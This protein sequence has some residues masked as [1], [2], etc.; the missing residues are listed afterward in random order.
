[1]CVCAAFVDNALNIYFWGM[2]Q[3]DII[4]HT[5]DSKPMYTPVTL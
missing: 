1:M 5:G 4:D 2:L 3:R